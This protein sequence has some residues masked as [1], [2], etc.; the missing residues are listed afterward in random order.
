V[1]LDY[2]HTGT[3]STHFI[4]SLMIELVVIFIIKKNETYMITEHTTLLVA[5]E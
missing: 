2:G 5:F 3:Y 1:D 4:V